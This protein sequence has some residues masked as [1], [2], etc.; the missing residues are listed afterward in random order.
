[1]RD[2]YEVGVSG[3]RVAGNHSCANAGQKLLAR[4]NLLAH[5]MAAALRLHLVLNVARCETNASVFGD[6]ASDIGGST[7]S[8]E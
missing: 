3:D 4:D 5:K 8:A 7:E 6:S 1:M 2:T